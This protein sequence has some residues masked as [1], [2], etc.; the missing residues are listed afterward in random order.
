MVDVSIV[1]PLYNEEDNVQLLHEAISNALADFRPSYEVV[2]VDEG[3]RDAT[4]VR[5]AEVA[6]RDGRVRIV[7]FRGN[8]GQ[9]AAMAAGIQTARGDIIV[10]MDG[11]LQNDPLAIP[12]MVELIDAGSDIVVGWR[13]KVQD[14]GLDRKSGV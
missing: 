8:Y 5:A 9:N 2:L 7:K 4:F 6:E 11:D 3:S 1:V 12:S 14:G 10:T 13:K